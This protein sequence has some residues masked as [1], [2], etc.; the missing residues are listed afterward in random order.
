[1]S[2]V[3]GHISHLTTVNIVARSVG[4]LQN[5]IGIERSEA[6]VGGLQNIVVTRLQTSSQKVGYHILSVQIEGIK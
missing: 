5:R 6:D 1:M 4:S 2:I 3:D